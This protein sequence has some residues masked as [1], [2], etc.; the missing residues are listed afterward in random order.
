MTGIKWVCVCFARFN[1]GMSMLRYKALAFGV[2][3]GVSLTAGSWSFAAE[4]ES[5]A[6]G[7]VTAA[8]GTA[9]IHSAQGTRA[10]DLQHEKCGEN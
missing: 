1:R 6:I 3:L 5:Q 8:F 7:T 10:G 4:P 9:T 2:A